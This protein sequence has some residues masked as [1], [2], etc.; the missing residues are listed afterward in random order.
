MCAE[1]GEEMSAI[2][3]VIERA[4]DRMRPFWQAEE[5][6]KSFAALSGDAAVR[7]V[8]SVKFLGLPFEHCLDGI[9]ALTPSR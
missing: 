4:E 1:V 7:Y 5:G 8:E 3:V 9:R 6:P 2:S